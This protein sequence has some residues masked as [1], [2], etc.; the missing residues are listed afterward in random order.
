[1]RGFSQDSKG[2]P[3]A[4]REVERNFLKSCATFLQFVAR[5]SV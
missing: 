1:M 5:P 4:V 3:K 2:H